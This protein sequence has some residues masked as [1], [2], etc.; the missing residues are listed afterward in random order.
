MSTEDTSIYKVWEVWEDVVS[1]YRPHAEVRGQIGSVENTRSQLPAER[2]VVTLCG[3]LQHLVCLV[4][5]HTVPETQCIYPL[6]YWRSPQPTPP[7]LITTKVNDI[8]IDHGKKMSS[9]KTGLHAW[10]HILLVNTHTEKRVIKLHHLEGEGTSVP[11][12]IVTE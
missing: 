10:E 1:I 12:G 7:L 9:F 3:A 4:C 8:I 6:H 11:V 2:C 5:V